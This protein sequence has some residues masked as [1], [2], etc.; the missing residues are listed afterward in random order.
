[1]WACIKC[2]NECPKHS[3][4]EAY[5]VPIEDVEIEDVDALNKSTSYIVKCPGVSSE[6]E[7]ISCLARIAFIE[8][9]SHA[10]ATCRMW[11]KRKSFAPLTTEEIKQSISSE[12][13][14]AENELIEK[15]KEK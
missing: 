14:D 13:E 10:K 6:D 5:L 12:E 9:G 11:K 3:N 1:M 15:E 7:R 4:K 2:I 8:K